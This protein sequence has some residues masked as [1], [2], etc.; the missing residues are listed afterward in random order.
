MEIGDII[1]S[2]EVEKKLPKTIRI[3]F[4]RDDPFENAVLEALDRAA[5]DIGTT[6]K[7][8]VEHILENVLLRGGIENSDDKE[9]GIDE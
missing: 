7:R 1:G 6:R 9:D 4:R 5:R 2:I 3:T 8:L